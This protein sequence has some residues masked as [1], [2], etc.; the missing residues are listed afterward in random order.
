MQIAFPFHVNQGLA[1]ETGYDD[2]IRQMIE[3]V[4]FT[5]PN[6]RVNRPDFGCGLG[7]LVFE[8]PNSEMITAI[9]ALVQSSLQQWLRDLIQ[10]EGVQVMQVE[11]TLRISI[12][13]IVLLTRERQLAE[14]ERSGG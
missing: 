1:A 3:Q 5:E 10:V 12:Q 14:F 2:H 6:E 4:L 8:S 7:R 13:Y 9:Q 11:S